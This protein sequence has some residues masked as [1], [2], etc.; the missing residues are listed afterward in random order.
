[1]KKSLGY[2]NEE[3]LLLGNVIPSSTTKFSVKEHSGEY[4]AC[5]H[6]TFTHGKCMLT[7]ADGMCRARM[8]NKE[9]APV[10]LYKGYRKSVCALAHN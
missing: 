10:C 3:V 4:Y 7:C 8:H 5:V 2:F 1:M 6:V 9:G